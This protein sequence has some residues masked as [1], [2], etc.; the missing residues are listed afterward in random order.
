MGAGQLGLPSK[1]YDALLCLGCFGFGHFP[2]AAMDELI[3][4]VRKEGIITVGIRKKVAETTDEGKGFL[5]KMDSL[6]EKQAWRL[7]K[8]DF[9]VS[10]CTDFYVYTFEVLV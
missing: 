1:Q 2:A 6:V 8:R 3:S 4:L 7:I 10:H 5:Q 9:Y